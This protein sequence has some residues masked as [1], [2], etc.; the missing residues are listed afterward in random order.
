[1]DGEIVRERDIRQ[2]AYSWCRDSLHGSWAEITEDELIVQNLVIP[3]G[4]N[5]K[6]IYLCYLPKTLEPDAGVPTCVLLRFHKHTVSR[7]KESVVKNAVVFAILSEKGMGPKLYGIYHDGRIEEY[8][9]TRA[10]LTLE[11]SIPSISRLVARKLAQFHQL[12]MPLCKEPRW[13]KNYVGGKLAEIKNIFREHSG[14]SPKRKKLISFNIEQEFQELL[15][16]FSRVYSP[17]VFCHNDLHEGN[18]LY[19]KEEMNPDRQLTIIDWELCSYNFRGFDIGNHFT[20]R[21]YDHSNPE[22]PFFY[23]IPDQ[24]PSRKQQYAFFREYLTCFGREE[25]DIS[26]EELAMMYVEVNTYALASH[27]MWGTWAIVQAET[28]KIECGYWELAISRFESYFEMKKR[29][30]T[31]RSED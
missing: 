1:M 17:V 4:G 8:I 7:C 15:I 27:F 10:L 23:H 12:D 29:L 16:M 24:Y 21:C 22:K 6:Q 19:L 13:F 5:P 30:P 9:P 2:K 31:L 3:S 14:R 26:E 11:L 20:T 18:I 25:D 28:C